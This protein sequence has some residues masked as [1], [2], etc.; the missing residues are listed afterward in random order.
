MER[1]DLLL[2]AAV[3]VAAFSAGWMSY[4]ITR[5]SLYQ[6]GLNATVDAQNGVRDVSFDN[7]SISLMHSNSAKGSFFLDIDR[8][9][10]P[11]RKIEVEHDGEIHQKQVFATV[12]GNTYILYLRYSDNP[13]K[14][15]DAWMTVYKVEEV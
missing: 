12:R 6:S 3:F 8:D 11:E 1:K 5:P 15:D 10:S 7:R 13:E 2:L 9:G 14:K 4:S